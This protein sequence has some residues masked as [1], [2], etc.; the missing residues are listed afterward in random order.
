MDRN[1]FRY[2]AGTTFVCGLT[3]T[4]SFVFQPSGSCRWM[5]RN[6]VT[7]GGTYVRVIGGISLENLKAI[8]ESLAFIEEPAK[9][10]YPTR[11]R[12]VNTHAV[13]AI[14]SG[15]QIGEGTEEQCKAGLDSV[16]GR[17]S[18]QLVQLTD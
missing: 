2:K 16:G 14:D 6:G 13:V 9:S 11:S 18:F 3:I 8:C 4:G 5:S 10:T 1:E 17:A 12:K 15:L 7:H